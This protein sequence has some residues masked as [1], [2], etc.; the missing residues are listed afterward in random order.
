MAKINN[1]SGQPAQA[2][3]WG[4]PRTVRDRLVN[5]AQLDARK[6]KKKGDPKNPALASSALLD[7]IGPAH[8]AEELRLPLPPVPEGHDADIEAYLDREHLQS[9][10]ER[11]AGE[12][13]AGLEKSLS[14]VRATGERLDRLKALIARERQMLALVDQVNREV[15]EIHR[16]RKEEQ[17]AEAY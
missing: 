15:E 16:R 4:A 1:P 14:Q 12:H 10:A 6:A 17:E 11:H 8:S 7:F 5:P 2:W 3:P 13:D 9:V